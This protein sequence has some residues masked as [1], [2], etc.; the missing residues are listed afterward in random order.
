MV[1]IETRKRIVSV[2][3][4]LTMI[5]LFSGVLGRTTGPLQAFDLM[6][7]LG[8]FG[9]IVEDMNFKGKG[10]AGARDGFLFTLTIIPSTMLAL[11]I[12]EVCQHFGALDAARRLLTPFFRPIYGLP[13]DVGIAFASAFTSS[14][15]GSAMT[16]RL[17]DDKLISDDQRTVFVAYQYAGS[18]PINNTFGAGSPLLPVS[19]I[20]AGGIILIIFITKTIGANLVRL[21]IALERRRKTSVSKAIN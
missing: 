9:T 19:V 11:G 1:T 20:P 3:A 17:Y 8:E 5:V 4:L 14:D 13:G 16:K 7:L 21:F 15:V 12:A 6:S 2:V 18:A 10:G